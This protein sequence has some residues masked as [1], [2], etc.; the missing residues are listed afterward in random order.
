MDILCSLT[1]KYIKG[2]FAKH[3]QS[4]SSYRAK[5]LGMLAIRL[6]LL[7]IEAHYMVAGDK[8]QVF[9]DN[10][11]AIYTF[12]RRSQRVTSGTKNADIQRILRQIQGRMTSSITSKHVCAHQDKS[13]KR[14]ALSIAAQLNC[15]CDDLVKSAIYEAMMDAPG[16]AQGYVLPL[17]DACVFINDV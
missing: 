4:A 7:A 8:T 5:L 11:G 3:S 14:S 10:I 9:C 13:K 17:E 1:K 15:R 12:Q 16:P 2:S 6:F